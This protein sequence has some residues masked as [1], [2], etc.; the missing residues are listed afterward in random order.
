MIS[1]LRNSIACLALAAAAANAQNSSELSTGDSDRQTLAVQQKVEDL[2]D[3]GEFERAF[4]I[5]RNE[6]VPLGDKYAQYM[7]GFMYETGTGVVRD[8]I[9][10]A[11]WY[12]LS[13]ERGTPEF[14]AVRRQLT[15]TFSPEEEVEAE[16]RYRALREQYGDLVVLLNRIRSD[17]RELRTRT[18]SRLGSDASPVTV[19]EGRTGNVRAGENYFGTIERRI[20]ERVQKLIELGGFHDLEA[21][22]DE[23]DIRELERR[24]RESIQA[25]D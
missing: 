18:G 4:F 21:D 9:Q 17:L 3:E 14:L 24:V 23:L 1:L 13:A 6:L 15:R 19:I 5:Y 22:V 20:E 10:A 7:V 16:V 11:A 2:F 25:P 8:P 12:R